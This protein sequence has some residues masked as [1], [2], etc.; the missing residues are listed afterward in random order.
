MNKTLSL[1]LV[2][3]VTGLW[4]PHGA[5]GQPAGGGVVQA[6]GSPAGR[7]NQDTIRT[8]TRFLSQ[9]QRKL[10]ADERYQGL[11]PQAKLK[12]LLTTCEVT[13][14]RV[15][16]GFTGAGKMLE[17]IAAVLMAALSDFELERVMRKIDS[18]VPK[19]VLAAGGTGPSEEEFSLAESGFEDLRPEVPV[20]VP[21][22][23]TM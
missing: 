20:V 5:L 13:G 3:L 8:L 17:E 2:C 23:D 12:L 11:D 19:T 10:D 6:Q 22:P 4:T 21:L 18:L 9:L 14:F 7:R 1:V 16:K 15:P